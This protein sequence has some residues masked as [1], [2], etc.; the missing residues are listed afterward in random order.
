MP[1]GVTIFRVEPEAEQEQFGGPV[2]I[3]PDIPDGTR[4]DWVIDELA[5]TASTYIDV[6]VELSTGAS[7]TG[8]DS[9]CNTGYAISSGNV[10]N[11]A[12]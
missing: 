5:P 7:Y 2:D 10:D 4:F 6:F 8:G 12:E 11:P 9:V 3:D 1:A